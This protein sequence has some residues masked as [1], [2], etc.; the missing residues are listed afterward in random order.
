MLLK[1]DSHSFVFSKCFILATLD[2]VVRDSDPIPATLDMVKADTEPI[3]GTMDIV[4]VD[5]YQETRRDV[6][7]YPVITFYLLI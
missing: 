4:M 1:P 7:I 5:L 2:R 3:P 6:V